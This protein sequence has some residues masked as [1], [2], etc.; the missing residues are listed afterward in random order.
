MYGTIARLRLKPGT[1]Q[2]LGELFKEFDGLGIAG[3]VRNTIYR[4]D[5]GSNE[6]MMAVAFETKEAYVANAESP[7]QDEIFQK[8]R[9]LL[10]ADPD[11]NDGEIVHA[12]G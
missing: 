11:W 10:E 6:Y 2:Q 8:L 5:A 9:A 12:T 4:L 7:Q 1:E 3:F